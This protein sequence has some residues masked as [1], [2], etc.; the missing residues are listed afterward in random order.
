[1][2]FYRPMT[3]IKNKKAKTFIVNA[4]L[5]MPG[6]D[7]EYLATIRDQITMLGRFI[8]EIDSE[9]IARIIDYFESSPSPLRKMQIKQRINPN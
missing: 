2:K 8:N 1:M 9:M 5:N 3:T 7:A 6:D 4:L